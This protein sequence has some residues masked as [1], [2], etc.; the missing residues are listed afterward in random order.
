MRLSVCLLALSLAG[1]VGGAALIG[2]WALGLAIVVDSLL[3]GL[4]VLF[5][6]TAPR[7]EVPVDGPPTLAQVLEN[8]RRAA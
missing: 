5:R 7:R 8:A 6:D 4:W 3:V 1:I 2:R